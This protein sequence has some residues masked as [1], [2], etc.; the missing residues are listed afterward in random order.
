MGNGDDGLGVRGSSDGGG[1]SM[2][3]TGEDFIIG[4]IVRNAFVGASSCDDDDDDD[5]NVRPSLL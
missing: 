4:T 5:K 3:S 2:A 1:L